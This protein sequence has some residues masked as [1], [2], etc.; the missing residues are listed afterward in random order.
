MNRKKYVSYLREKANSH[1]FYRGTNTQLA[2]GMPY[3]HVTDAVRRAC[4]AMMEYWSY[5][6]GWKHHK[7]DAYLMIQSSAE[8]YESFVRNG[9]YPVFDKRRL[10]RM[11]RHYGKPCGQYY[12]PHCVAC[13]GWG[14]FFFYQKFPS[15]NRVLNYVSSLGETADDEID[16]SLFSNPEVY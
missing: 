14:M 7:F 1:G 5:D 13:A 3:K 16:L 4:A 10:K 9:H 8:A 15:G 12:H 6:N 11:V 2:D